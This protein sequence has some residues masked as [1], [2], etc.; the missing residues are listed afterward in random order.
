MTEVNIIT[1]KTNSSLISSIGFLA[2]VVLSSIAL[3]FY[4]NSLL[5]E[6]EKIKTNIISIE[7]NINDI[8]K[9]KNLQIASLLELNASIIDSFELMNNVTTYIIHMN[10]IATKYNLE[11]NW[12][13][14]SNWKITTNVKAISD[15]EWIA[16][17]KIRDFIKK[18]RTDSKSL[19][20]LDFVNNIEWM[21]EIKFTANF[22]IK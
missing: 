18:Y 8:N 9:D 16:F 1:K 15:K 14:L 2:I 3:N 22:K 13:N 11:F 6:I 5:V 12:F 21:D 10:N 19:F 17:Q 20:D 4:N 7:K